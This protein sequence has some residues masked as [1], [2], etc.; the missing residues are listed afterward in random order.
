MVFCIVALVVFGIM[1][2]FSAS[3]RPLAK[4][5]FGCVFRM[6]TLRKCESNFDQKMKTRISVGLL[7]WNKTVGRF[8]FRHFEAISWALV[9]L[10][11]VS[12]VLIFVGIYNFVLFGNCNGP[13]GGFCIYNGLLG[14]TNKTPELLGLPTDFN[15]GILFGN[16]NASLTIVEFGCFSCPFTKSAEPVVQQALREFGGQINVLWKPFPLPTHRFSREAALAG[17]CAN[18]QGKFAEF[19][20]QLFEKQLLFQEEGTKV[21]NDIAQQLNLNRSQFEQCVSSNESALLVDKTSW[22]GQT[23]GVYGTPT[24]FIGNKAL[25]GPPSYD[26][27]KKA[28]ENALNKKG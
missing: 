11:V 14:G 6:A 24:F 5:A 2:I 18:Q 8:A 7:K 26:E 1:G 10:T 16:P 25:V 3:H 9:L 17:V 19:K 28:V 27:F 23:L 15:T 22:E 20:Q 21:F 13:A 12:L 4:E